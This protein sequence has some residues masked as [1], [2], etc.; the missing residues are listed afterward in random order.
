MRAE[1]IKPLPTTFKDYPVIDGDISDY[2]PLDNKGSIVAL[3]FK[4]IADKV[5]AAKVLKSK[6]VVNAESIEC[7]YETMVTV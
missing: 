1:N 7:T 4:K 6:F 5:K 2:R 3:R